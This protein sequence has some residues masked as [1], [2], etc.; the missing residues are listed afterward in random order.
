MLSQNGQVRR[1]KFSFI[2]MIQP[3]QEVFIK[4]NKSVE[5]VIQAI[6]F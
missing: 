2:K 3:H 5:E 6:D 4:Y 1:T